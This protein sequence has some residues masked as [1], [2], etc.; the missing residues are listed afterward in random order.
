[1]WRYALRISGFWLY[2]KCKTA[3]DFIHPIR[4]KST[5]AAPLLQHFGVRH[6]ESVQMT[7]WVGG[8]VVDSG[9]FMMRNIIN[10]WQ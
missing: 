8:R 9:Y 5:D 3:S 10:G 6:N 1:M 4:G 7:W 2:V